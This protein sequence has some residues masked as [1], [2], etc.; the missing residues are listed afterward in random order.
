M[1]TCNANREANAVGSVSPLGTTGSVG[2][3]WITAVGTRL[4]VRAVVNINNNT[5][6]VY[7]A[8]YNNTDNFVLLSGDGQHGAVKSA[9]M[10]TAAD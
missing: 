9:R 4:D 5:A 6:M 1:S 2:S 8:G 10:T 3:C 7:D